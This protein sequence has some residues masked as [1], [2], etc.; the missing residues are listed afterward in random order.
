VA[1]NDR[2]RSVAIVG[3]GVD[4]WMVAA[5]LAVALGARVTVRIVT[6]PNDSTVAREVANAESTLPPLRAFNTLLGMDEDK[7]IRGCAGTF[8]LGT[9]F[10]GWREGG[11]YIQPCGE[12]GATLGGVAFHQ[13]LTRLHAAGMAVRQEEYCLAA[14]AARAGSFTRPSQDPSSVQST[15]TYALHLDGARYREHLNAV[16]QLH[17]VSVVRGAIGEVV[18]GHNGYVA[19]LIL[20]DGERIEADLFVDASGDEA[21]LIGTAMDV[22]FEDWSSGLPCSRH[23]AAKCEQR[24]L[25]APLTRVEAAKFGW[26][27]RVPLQGSVV[28]GYTY[29]PA[30]L[31]DES[32]ARALLEWMEASPNT[33]VVFRSAK[34]GRRVAPWQGNCVAIG[35]AAGFIEPLDSAALHLTQSMIVRLLSLFPPRISNV[36]PLEYNRLVGN[37]LERT[38]D[39]AIAHYATAQRTEGEF[40]RQRGSATIPDSLAY[41]MAQYTSRGKLVSY[42]QEPLPEAAWLALYLGQG[43]WPKR[44]EALAQAADPENVRQQLARVRAAIEQAANAMPPHAEYIHQ[45]SLGAWMHV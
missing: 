44:C 23:V 29:D 20:Q 7:L 38:R 37:E 19:A 12:F 24:Q 22:A 11:R 8:K 43:I 21:R 34:S 4:A 26:M 39:L 25:G 14:I 16:A 17:G 2:V 35:T 9:E 10:V 5:A 13:Y 33:D 28:C 40:W 41:K 3:D 30:L 15:M 42:D 32:A 27:T 18:L 1:D 6:S 45:H 36:E 31:D